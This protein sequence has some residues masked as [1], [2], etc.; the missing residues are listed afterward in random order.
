M[1]RTLMIAL[2]I[3]ATTQ[4]V[5]LDAIPRHGQSGTFGPNGVNQRV[6]IKINKVKIGKDLAIIQVDLGDKKYDSVKSK[7]LITEYPVIGI[8][9]GSLPTLQG[10]AN[11]KGQII[12]EQFR[13]KLVANGAGMSIQIKKATL[14]ALLS[15]LSGQGEH[16][17]LTITITDDSLPGSPALSR[18]SKAVPRLGGTLYT[19][20]FELDIKESDKILIAQG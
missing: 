12:G 13:A 18:D 19:K 6:A 1:F 7:V 4:A 15:N 10:T 2:F 9:I 17:N 5:A 14:T 3:S 16:V 8:T 20:E 11:E